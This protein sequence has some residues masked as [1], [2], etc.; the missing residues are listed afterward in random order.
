MKSLPGDYRRRSELMSWFR[1]AA[2]LGPA[3]VHR[4]AVRGLYREM[5]LREEAD[6]LGQSASAS[7]R[8]HGMEA[9]KANTFC[10]GLVAGQSASSVQ[11]WARPLLE[12][13]R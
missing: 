5:E 10:Q 7:C 13:L 1:E 12:V 4:M 11:G 3:F 9:P 8:L 2:Q 6:F